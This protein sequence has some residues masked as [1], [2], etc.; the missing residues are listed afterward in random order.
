MSIHTACVPQL[1]KMLRNLNTWLDL[2]GEHAAARG[3]AADLAAYLDARLYPDQYALRQQIQGACDA[4]KFA[5]ARVAGATPPVHE[6]GPQ[7]IDELRA[8]I[9]D[10]IAFLEGLEPADFA[11]SAERAVPLPFA[12]GKGMTAANYFNEM[13]LPNFYFHTVTAYAIL[14]HVGVPLGKRTYIG[15]L[16]MI[17]L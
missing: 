12:P 7:T 17:D 16:T 9:T 11:G 10:V 6:D 2:A 1:T 4:A 8:R 3:G 5:G 14:R 13:A 15:S